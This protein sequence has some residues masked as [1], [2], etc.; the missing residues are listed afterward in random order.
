MHT[1]DKSSKATK[2]IK[3]KNNTSSLNRKNI[4]TNSLNLTKNN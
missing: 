2:D 4:Y 3:Y 1:K